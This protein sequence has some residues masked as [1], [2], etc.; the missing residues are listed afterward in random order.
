MKFRGLLKRFSRVVPIAVVS[1]SAGCQRYVEVQQRPRQPAG[2]VRL[3]LTGDATYAQ[4]APL[5]SNILTLEG[6]ILSVN[7]SALTLS[8]TQLTR[9]A[10]ASESWRGETVAIP[11]RDVASLQ[12]QTLSVPRTLATVGAMIAGSIAVR[13]GMNTG[14]STGSRTPKPGGGN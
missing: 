8:V 10:G 7:D 9:R 11:R 1:L 4:R 6:R 12:R 2:D 3:T 5:G 13:R 14:E